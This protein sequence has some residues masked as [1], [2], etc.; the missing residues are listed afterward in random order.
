MARFHKAFQV[1]MKAGVLHGIAVPNAA[2]NLSDLEVLFDGANE[3]LGQAFFVMGSA[4]G[5]G[6]FITSSSLP[7]IPVVL[8]ESGWGIR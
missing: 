7:L 5:Y 4:V 6:A 8:L 1:L 3:F 2:S